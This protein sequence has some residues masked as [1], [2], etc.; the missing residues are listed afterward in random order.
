M[1]TKEKKRVN[2]LLIKYIPPINPINSTNINFDK[3]LNFILYN[4]IINYL[5]L[6]ILNYQVLLLLI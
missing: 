6:N 2:K 5:C 3:L 4:T 1:G